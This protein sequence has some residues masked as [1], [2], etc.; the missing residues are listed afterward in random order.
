MR[1]MFIVLFVAAALSVGCATML[2][3]GQDV[4]EAAL[5]GS[6]AGGVCAELDKLKAE[7]AAGAVA[8]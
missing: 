4:C 2:D 7:E 3:L 5:G 8:E 6:K 1:S